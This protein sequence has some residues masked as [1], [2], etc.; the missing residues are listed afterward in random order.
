MRILEIN[1]VNYGS[2]GC[3]MRN[4]AL[5]AEKMG[6]EVFTSCQ[7]GKSTKGE[8]YHRHI[9]I[10]NRID[11]NIHLR[12]GKLTGKYGMYSKKITDKFISEIDE[13]KPDLIHIHNLHKGYINIGI[14]FDYIKQRNVPVVWT[15]HD[16]WSFTGQCPYFDI[17]KCDKWKNG[18]GDCPSY[19]EY[20]SNIDSTAFMY[21]KKKEWFQGINNMTIVTPSK[22]LSYLVKESFLGEYNIKV[23]NNGIDLEVFKPVESELR[24][25]HHLEGKK[26]IL[27]VAS[28]WDARKGLDVFKFLANELDDSFKV[29][30]VG[31][32]KEQ[33]QELPAN[34]IGITRTNSAHELAQYYAMADVFLNPTYEDNFPTVNIEALACGTPVLTF[35]TGGSAECLQEGCGMIVTKDN[36]L[37]ILFNL[38]KYDFQEE[39]CVAAGRQYSAIEKYREY[40]RLY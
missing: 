3:I 38:D 10:G 9:Y 31:V 30:V 24:K 15:L 34:M 16:C 21:K 36:V 25:Q 4:I 1:S 12:L 13:L 22:W 26:I 37:D 8:K 2:T 40:V 6:V 5:E 28:L 29:M 23:I 27:G 20:P 32:T 39:K 7:L 14:L 33:I 17:V 35:P 18:C 11:R 19:K